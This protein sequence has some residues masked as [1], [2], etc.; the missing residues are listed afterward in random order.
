MLQHRAQLQYRSTLRAILP[1][2]NTAEH[3]TVVHIVIYRI[4]TCFT[5][6]LA[7]IETYQV[8]CQELE[9]ELTLQGKWDLKIEWENGY[10]SFSIHSTI[11]ALLF[12]I[13]EYETSPSTNLQN[14]VGDARGL[15]FKNLCT[16]DWVAVMNK[17]SRIG[18]NGRA[19]AHLYQLGIRPKIHWAFPFSQMCLACSRLCWRLPFITLLCLLSAG[20]YFYRLP[21]S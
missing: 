18:I 1:L 16:S 8:R 11:S 15:Y 9:L 20:Q 6:I 17:L 2:E 4:N 19:S 12:Q 14:Q 13:Y 10:F 3:P 5:V 21:T 7:S